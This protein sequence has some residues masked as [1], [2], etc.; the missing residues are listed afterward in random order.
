MERHRIDEHKAFE[1]LRTEAREGSRKVV[2]VADAVATSYRSYR[3][4]N[5]T[6]RPDRLI[7]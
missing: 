3:A 5:T 4:P 1:M 6:S 7:R 2:D